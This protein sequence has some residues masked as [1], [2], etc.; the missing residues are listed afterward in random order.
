ML[1]VM[2]LL[3]GIDVHR[4]AHTICLTNRDGQEISQRFH[5]IDAVSDRSTMIRVLG[6]KLSTVYT[7][8]WITVQVR[9]H[10]RCPLLAT[11]NVNL[12][13][14]NSKIESRIVSYR[15]RRLPAGLTR[16]D[17][18]VASTGGNAIQR[19]GILGQ[20]ISPFA[21]SLSP[22]FPHTTPCYP[23]DKA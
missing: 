9:I 14:A 6:D 15:L 23:Q 20:Q 10:S 21:G 4:K 16:D 2:P 22:T 5:I 8:V 17:R 19:A 1:L 18:P 11:T 7:L 12:H 3:V 13:T